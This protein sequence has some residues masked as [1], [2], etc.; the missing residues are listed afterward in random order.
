MPQ[1]PRNRLRRAAGCVRSRALAQRHVV[2]AARGRF[3]SEPV[4]WTSAGAP[5]SARFDDRYHSEAGALAQ[6]RHVFL[7]GCGLPGAWAGKA[8]WRILETGFGLG[9]NFLAAWAAWRADPARP[10]LLHF[11]SVEAYPVAAADLLRAARDEPDL[12][13]LA[14]QLAAQWQGLLPGLHRL[15]FD[16][17]RV[18][19]TLCVGPVQ[20]MLRAQRFAADSLYLDGFSPQRNPDMW[21]PETLRTLARFARRGT[22]LATW[23]IARAVRDALASQGFVLEKAPGLPPKRDCLRGVFAPAWEPRRHEPWPGEAVAVPGD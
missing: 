14:Q 5:R 22:R 19:L 7:G 1:H 6:A 12:A 4:D 21:S 9:L 16:G 23:T 17:G 8:Q 15:A 10:G 13:P 3:M 18:L 11:V 20:P 2:R